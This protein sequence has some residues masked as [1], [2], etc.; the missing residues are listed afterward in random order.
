MNFSPG[1]VQD[2][3]N[4]PQQRGN[5]RFSLAERRYR[6]EDMVPGNLFVSTFSASS[7]SLWDFY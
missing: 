4:M 1:P 5:I 3:P 2:F 6:N 7:F